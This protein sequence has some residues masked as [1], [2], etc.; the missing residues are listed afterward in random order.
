[1]H[2]LGFIKKYLVK[3][4]LVIN[5]YVHTL[6][7]SHHHFDF[8]Q[9]YTYLLSFD[10][11]HWTIPETNYGP[12]ELFKSLLDE[13]LLKNEWI[14]AKVSFGNKKERWDDDDVVESGIHVIK[15]LT[16][17]DDFQFTDYTLLPENVKQ[18]CHHPLV[19]SCKMNGF[20]AELY[21]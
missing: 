13:A 15:H 3:V 21:G 5:G 4:D 12:R 2:E 9:D 11:Q 19:Q 16:S 18:D 8:H 7:H 14:H 17:M 1:M 10:L 20:H 6:L